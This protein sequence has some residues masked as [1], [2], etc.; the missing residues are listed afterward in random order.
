MS[1]P[2]IF[3]HG[4]PGCPCCGQRLIGDGDDGDDDYEDGTSVCAC[5][6]FDDHANNVVFDGL[7]L[8]STYPSYATGKLDNATKHTGTQ[9][10]EHPHHYCFTPSFGDGLRIWFWFKV[11]TA[12]PTTTNWQGVVTK[13]RLTSYPTFTGEWGI[14]WKTTPTSGPSLAFIHS[15]STVTTGVLHTSTIVTG[16]WYF[17]HW[18]I[19]TAT[20]VSTASIWNAETDTKLDI[21]PA[22][23]AGTLTADPAESMRVGNNTDG[24]ILGAN[25]GEF[26]IDNL[27][28]THGASSAGFL[29]KLGDGIACPESGG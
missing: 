3:K 18:D 7:H 6:P 13:G 25:S 29:Y 14:F 17:I 9:H 12:P 22:V 15:S 28:F 26:L 5:Y 21:D 27:G 23:L 10:H 24:D 2:L 4:N 19:N 1:L 16:N 8:A 20:A 11:V